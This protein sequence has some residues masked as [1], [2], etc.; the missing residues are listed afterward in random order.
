MDDA[1]MR[2]VTISLSPAAETR[3]GAGADSAS[4][5]EVI[6]VRG[7]GYR[8]AIGFDDSVPSTDTFDRWT[9]IYEV[10]TAHEGSPLAQLHALVLSEQEGLKPGST[11][12]SYVQFMSERWIP[13]VTSLPG[14]R[15][16]HLLRGRRGARAG[17]LAYLGWFTD[18][19]ARE[20]LLAALGVQEVPSALRGY[21]ELID[22][23]FRYY[24][25]PS[26]HRFLR[27][28]RDT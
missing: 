2:T 23:S 10:V 3:D 8:A 14:Y 18:V 27:L 24:L 28:Q 22:E 9:T 11:E 17:K 16:A 4:D 13:G 6:R 19:Q 26:L 15:A 21:R 1:L 25:D 20:S 12:A 7:D 5:D